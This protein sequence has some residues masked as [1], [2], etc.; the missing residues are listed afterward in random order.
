MHNQ[1]F[2]D[3]YS[4]DIIYLRDARETLLSHPLRIEIPSLCN[5][6]L[7]R[8]YIVAVIGSIEFMLEAWQEKDQHGIIECYLAE[9]AANKRMSNEDKVNLLK[10][11]FKN[12]GF[13]V[14]DHIFDQFLAI[15]YIRNAIV[16]ASWKHPN[17]DLKQD[18]ITWINKCGFPTDTRQL[19]LEHWNIVDSVYNHMTTYL[20]MS[21][22]P[23]KPSGKIT[24][25][26]RNNKEKSAIIKSDTWPNLFRLNLERISSEID[27]EIRL[28]VSNS[29]HISL[30]SE[31]L[32]YTEIKKE[33]IDIV[34]PTLESLSED[35]K[36]T[37]TL[38]RQTN[39][40]FKNID[41][42][43]IVNTLRVYRA[44]FAD[45]IRPHENFF[46]FDLEEIKDEY[47]I[48][49]VEKCF[50]KSQ[51]LNTSEIIAA[52]KFGKRAKSSI[53]NIAPLSLFGFQMNL[54]GKGCDITNDF[55]DLYADLFEIAQSWYCLLE[56]GPS[57]KELVDYHRK[58]KSELFLS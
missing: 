33:L 29:K 17:G 47:S 3:T 38:F 26:E 36:T 16:H 35:A 22:I 51:Q 10:A 56:G 20:G 27:D 9:T 31:K 21:A 18:Q 37:L 44:M 2:I 23:Y 43:L 50:P 11:T 30:N 25:A 57:P 12:C 49:L 42:E 41:K 54:I 55:F 39:K 52:L 40:I 8:L 6:A 28:I 53:A 48:V 14:E 5:A 1:Q 15:K 13:D 34:S 19:T 7:C 4:D 32:V 24:V 46:P 45:G 58:L